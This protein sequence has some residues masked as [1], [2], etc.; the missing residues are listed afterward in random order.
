MI[1]AAHASGDAPRVAFPAVVVAA[2]AVSA[3]LQPDAATQLLIITPIAVALGLPH[4]ALDLEIAKRLYP[5]RSRMRVASFGLCYFSLAAGVA[6]LW[7]AAPLLGL[8]LFLAYSA[9]HFSDDW[10]CDLPLS[11][12]L[13]VGAA[14]IGG[15]V[16]WRPSEVADVFSALTGAADG[17]DALVQVFAALGALAS[18]AALGLA[19]FQNGL[20]RAARIEIIALV[21]LA[22]AAP[23]LFYFA[24][25][26]CA[27]HSPRHLL[28]VAQ[29]LDVSMSRA[30]RLAAPITV[31]TIAGA[32]IA[33]LVF[34][35]A[36]WSADTAAARIMF[37]GL[38][39]LTIPHMALVDR[40]L[41]RAEDLRPAQR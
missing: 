1:V 9:L 4:G 6:A 19:L 12:R 20:K 14:V 27:L 38:A 25:Y 22:A 15:P 41:D 21:S 34:V 8:A 35:E 17:L 13:I 24:I 33:A 39:A 23:P 31:A 32:A 40:F 16:L 37:V 7:V 28:R 5:L 11:Q 10:R 29:V 2:V 30:L 18:A 26:F 36:G 3:I